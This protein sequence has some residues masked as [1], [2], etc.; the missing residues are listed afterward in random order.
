MQY[1]PW[2]P[3]NKESGYM[4]KIMGS[5]FS[6]ITNKN[7]LP[8]SK[9]IFLHVY[10]EQKVVDNNIIKCFSCDTILQFYTGW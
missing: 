1:G 10:P 5:Y 6:G 4:L 2:C 3:A 8:L 7:K 9:S